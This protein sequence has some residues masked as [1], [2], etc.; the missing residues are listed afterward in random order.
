MLNI[1]LSEETKQNIAYG[2]GMT[3]DELLTLDVENEEKAIKKK[4][5][6]PTEPDSRRVGRGSPYVSRCK[7]LFMK[8][9]EKNLK[10]IK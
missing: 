3:Y 2:T 10:R 4:L 8:D 1:K 6:F 5:V 9:V 7:F